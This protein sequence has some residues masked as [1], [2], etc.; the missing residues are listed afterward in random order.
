MF[1]NL[2]AKFKRPYLKNTIYRIMVF[3]FAPV[4]YAMSNLR[5][6]S[7]EE[8]GHLT[9]NITNRNTNTNVNVMT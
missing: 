2:A 4:L 8:H 5:D 3:L 9:N 7:E 1:K 6:N